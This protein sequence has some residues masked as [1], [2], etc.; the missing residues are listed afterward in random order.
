MRTAL[1]NLV[2]VSLAACRSQATPIQT[3]SAPEATVVIGPADAAPFLAIAAT[4]DAAVAEPAPPSTSMDAS[5]HGAPEHRAFGKTGWHVPR[6]ATVRLG[7]VTAQGKL[8]AALIRGIV[9]QNTGRFNS[10]YENGLRSNPN[11]N[12]RITVAFTIGIDGSVS[13]ASNGGSDL[14]DVKVVECVVRAAATLQFPQPED[15]RTVSVTV[16]L[17]FT[18]EE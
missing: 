12:G 5:S 16:P 6:Y 10:C 1:K 18:Y 4:H 11:L 3:P 14:P 8:T 15:G 9:R 17:S 2:L 13:T 7:T